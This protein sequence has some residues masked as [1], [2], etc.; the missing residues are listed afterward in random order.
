MTTNIAAQRFF[1]HFVHEMHAA[2]L[3][4]PQMLQ[5]AWR[6]YAV[7]ELNVTGPNRDQ[8]LDKLAL[9]EDD[10]HAALQTDHQ[11][12][13]NDVY[14]DQN[15]ALILVPGYT[16]ETLKN[17]SW[18]E[19]MERR[20]SPHNIVMLD[21]GNDGGPTRETEMAA[22]HPGGECLK[23]AYCRYPRSNASSEHIIEPLHDLLRQSQHVR[24]WVDAGRKLVF[25]GY[26]YGSPLSLELFAALNSGA[27]TD[28]FVLE[29]TA[30][31]LGLCGDIGGS[32]L[33]DDVTSDN[34]QFANVRKIVD[35]FKRHPGLQKGFVGKL[36]GVYTDQL[37][38][39]LFDGA[40]GLG[41]TVRQ[42]RMAQYAS[43]L[44]AHIKYHSISAVMPA[45]DYRRYLWHLNLDDWSMHKQAEMSWPHSIYNDGQVVLEDNL[46][47]NAPHIPAENNLHLGAVRTHHWGVSYKTFNLGNNRFPRP[48]FYRALT[49]AI[50]HALPGKIT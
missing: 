48:A 30:G 32:Y 14:R 10:I 6:P 11:P 12:V 44:P 49:Q 3:S 18:H 21:P 33:A 7:D 47:P 46:V 29:N 25:V 27:L 38:D 4:P 40:R 42:Q 8:N 26:S 5:H 17:L 1:Q 28:D 19:Q 20:D 45:D 43:Q 2:G 39:D 15:I 50:I 9:T 24:Q 34:P 31:F 23:I 13:D 35:F 16:H 22:G 41:H 37:L 36:A